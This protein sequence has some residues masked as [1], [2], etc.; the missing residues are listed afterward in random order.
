MSSIDVSIFTLRKQVASR[1]WPR[2]GCK[3]TLAV[4]LFLSLQPNVRKHVSLFFA[5][6]VVVQA[7]V[8]V[9]APYVHVRGTTVVV[10]RL[11]RFQPV[12]NS[13]SRLNAVTLGV[14]LATFTTSLC[15]GA[16]RRFGYALSYSFLN[17]AS[18]LRARALTLTHGL[19]A[20]TG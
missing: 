2:L 17:T 20:P 15:P 12:K 10:G 6:H 4:E 13:S 11:Y 5:D 19:L 14:H 8:R 1:S 9:L 16:A 7:P 3:G 18:P